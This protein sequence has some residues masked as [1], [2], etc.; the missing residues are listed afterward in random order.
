MMVVRRRAVQFGG[1][2][3]SNMSVKQVTAFEQL[4]GSYTMASNNH[5]DSPK[6][7][8]NGGPQMDNV[9]GPAA[10]RLVGVFSFTTS[11]SA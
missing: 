1:A 6:S 9:S 8:G 7:T 2:K 5:K 11:P 3:F 10:C 4:Q